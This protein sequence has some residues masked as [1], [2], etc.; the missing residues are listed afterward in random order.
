MSCS[1]SPPRSVSQAPILSPTPAT[2]VFL[3][4]FGN[5]MIPVYISSYSPPSGTQYLPVSPVMI[6]TNL[7]S[8]SFTQ[9]I[10]PEMFVPTENFDVARSRRGSLE[11]TA[12]RSRRNS[13]S[14][15][16]DSCFVEPAPVAPAF[17]NKKELVPRVL[18]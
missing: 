8:P 2:P 12:S 13:M 9:S 17:E 14:S 1:M 4:N 16:D 6:P 5:Q 18:K 15:C 7:P 11:P 3:D 10:S